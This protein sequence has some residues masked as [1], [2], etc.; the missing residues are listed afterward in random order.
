[1]DA[2]SRRHHFDLYYTHFNS[3]SQLLNKNFF[4]KYAV[5]YETTKRMSSGCLWYAAIQFPFTPPSKAPSHRR[6]GTPETS[7]WRSPKDFEFV[8]YSA[9]IMP[10]IA[11]YGENI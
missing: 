7:P 3:N 5:A 1:M 6:E 11:I 10:F 9:Q 8:R 2:T 4:K